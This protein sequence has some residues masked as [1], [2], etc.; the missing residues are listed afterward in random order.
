MDSSKLN[1]LG[2]ACRLWPT[3]SLLAVLLACIGLLAG[4]GTGAPQKQNQA[5]FTSGSNEADQRASQRMAKSEQLSGSDTKQ[6]GKTKT[7]KPGSQTPVQAEQKRTLYDRL[8]G[9]KGLLAIVNDFTPRVMEDPRVNWTRKGVKTGGL[10]HHKPSVT[11]NPTATNVAT[12]KTHFVQ[13]LALATG[14]P[15]NYQG[16]EIKATHAGM[17]ISNPEFDAAV[18]DLKATLDKLQIAN[19]E[20]KELLA[21]VESTRPEIVEQR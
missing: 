6:S 4:C 11:W 14:G 18:G 1:G 20:Q 21:I 12:L 3:G 5:F 2:G 10:F 17:Q 13:F 8:G 19:T 16:K 15:A 7:G 9:E